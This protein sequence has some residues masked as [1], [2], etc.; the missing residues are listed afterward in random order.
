MHTGRQEGKFTAGLYR[1]QAIPNLRVSPSQALL[2]ERALGVLGTPH[3]SSPLFAFGVLWFL[4]SNWAQVPECLS[5]L[6]HNQVT[7]L[8]LVIHVC[9]TLSKPMPVSVTMC[10]QVCPCWSLCMSVCP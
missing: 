10:A 6:V 1:L 2:W 7:G 4:T 5:F 9:E 8:M 3:H